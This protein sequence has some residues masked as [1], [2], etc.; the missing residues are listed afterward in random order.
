MKKS[1]WLKNSIIYH[2][3]IDRF[4]GFSSAKDWDKPKFLGGNIRGIIDNLDYLKNLGINTIWISPFYKTTEYHGY[5]IT[6]YYRV[7]SHFGV[8]ED[9]K[10]LITL[11]HDMQ[12]KIITDFVPNH[13]SKKHPFFID[14]QENRNSKYNNWFYFN[15]WPNEYLSFLS[16]KEI[17]KLNLDNKETS[18]YIINA[19][20]Y[21]LNFGFD[22]FRLDHVIGSSMSFWTRF[23]SEIK[24]LY[25][26]AV[27]IGEA[28][29]KGI[30]FKELKTIKIP[31]KSIK[32]LKRSSS[33]NILKEY[34]DVFDGILDFSF[35]KLIKLFVAYNQISYK[36]FNEILEKHFQKFPQN[37]YLPNFL[38][39]HDMNRF[40][41]ECKNDK[42][43]LKKAVEYQFKINQPTIIYYGTEIGLIQNKSIWSVRSHG[44]L[45]TRMPMSWRNYDEKLLDFYKNIIKNK[46]KKSF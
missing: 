7:D 10:E 16:I 6:D 27:L 1:D 9:I 40:L 22:G 43:K 2:I 45:Q 32:W 25:P 38:D 11:A 4:A 33:D 37:F 19:A 20:K 34:V 46:I 26:N 12:L 24:K 41:F 8:E 14:A 21:W 15:K 36:K 13:C 29:M 35:Q 30:K 31:H 42:N 3:L 5:H 23:N 44:D 39:N 18:D 17:P 28:W